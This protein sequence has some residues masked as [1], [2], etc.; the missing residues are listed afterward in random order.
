[1][2][3]F[4]SPQRRYGPLSRLLSGV[5][6]HGERPPNAVEDFFRTPEAGKFC[7][8]W[9]V[10]EI[11]AS[12]LETGCLAHWKKQGFEDLRFE[13]EGDGLTSRYGLTV[14]TRCG[15]VAEI[16]MQLVVWIDYI[17]IERIGVSY[18]SFGVEHLRLQN[19]RMTGEGLLPGQ[20]FPSSGMLRRMFGVIRHWAC[21][22]GASLITEIP[23]YFHT[24]YL[25]SE[26]FTYVDVEMEG[27][28]RAVK[29]DLLSHH[30]MGEVSSAFEQHRVTM[31]DRI[32]TWPT[33]VQAYALSHELAQRLEIPAEVVDSGV[34]QILSDEA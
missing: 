7:G 11:A 20:D 12:F 30:A 24:A 28:F 10:E 23:Q 16:L 6:L 34:F 15:E 26:Y 8:R 14:W 5:Q 1:M 22:I 17:E 27:L 25:F 2:P 31:N 29:R 3:Q 21:Q 33:E 19:P 32:W 13:L 18:P 4:D 9:S